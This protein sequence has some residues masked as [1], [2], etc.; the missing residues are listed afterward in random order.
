MAN[1]TKR[2]PE[3]EKAF[4]WSL[5]SGESV[6]GAC[7]YAGLGRQTVY[8]W[9]AEDAEF[10]AQWEA[11]VESGTSVLEDI[12]LER[13]KDKSDTLLIFLLKSRRPDVYAERKVIAGEVNHVH[14]GQ[15]GV[16]ASADWLAGVLGNGQERPSK[17][18]LH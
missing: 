11:A 13:A 9:R 15:V 12:A 8:E 3:K 16:S 18:P 2:T 17:K 7:E 6:R 4:L 14:S 10:K 1:R 5:A